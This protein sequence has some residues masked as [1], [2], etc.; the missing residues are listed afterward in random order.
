MKIVQNLGSRH[1]AEEAALRNT[2]MEGLI[3]CDEVEVEPCWG[4]EENFQVPALY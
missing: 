3:L 1:E 4:D 2:G